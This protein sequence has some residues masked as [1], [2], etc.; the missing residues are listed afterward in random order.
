MLSEVIFIISKVKWDNNINISFSDKGY[1]SLYSLY[2][3]KL[4]KNENEVLASSLIAYLLFKNFN[5]SK[6]FVS[7]SLNIIFNKYVI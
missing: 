1:F 2:N 5:L 7:K 3:L 6:S 4:S